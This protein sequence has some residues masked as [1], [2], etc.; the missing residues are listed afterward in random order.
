MRGRPDLY[1]H[2]L[3]V[4]QTGF[5]D[6]IAAAAALVMGEADEAQPVV[7]VRGLSLAGTPL[8]ASN[9]IR[10]AQEDLFR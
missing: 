3:H 4:T 10:A 2:A 5:A 7:L 8:P 6:Q 1:G 9:L